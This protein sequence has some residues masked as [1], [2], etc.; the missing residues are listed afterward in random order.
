MLGCSQE[1]KERSYP[2]ILDYL[3]RNTS[4]AIIQFLEV[5]ELVITKPDMQIAGMTGAHGTQEEVII[6]LN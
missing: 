1:S 4:L 5:F 6:K 3:R 2:D